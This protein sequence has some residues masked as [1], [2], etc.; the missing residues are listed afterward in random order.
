MRSQT[1]NTK[2]SAQ[3][4]GLKY[5]SIPRLNLNL[6]LI[7]RKADANRDLVSFPSIK[8]GWGYVTD[9]ADALIV[10]TKSGYL[11]IHE[12]DLDTLIQELEWIKEEMERRSRD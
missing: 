8:T 1:K 10:T 4:G 2:N 12:Q 6:E 9:G 7:M 3:N 5:S 11:R